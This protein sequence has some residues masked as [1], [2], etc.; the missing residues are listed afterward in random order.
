MLEISTGGDGSVR[1]RGRL[2]AVQAERQAD[3][4]G[5]L[6][7]SVTLD[8]AELDYISSAGLGLLFGTH[9]RL[10]TGGGGLRLINLKPHIRELFAIAQFDTIF[11]I[12]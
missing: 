7:G 5:V 8:C 3:A 4:F 1:L 12:D 6:T 9:K 2:D 11:Q 10:S